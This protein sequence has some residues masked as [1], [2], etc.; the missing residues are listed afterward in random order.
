MRVMCVFPFTRVGRDIRTT[1]L[2]VQ[3]FLGWRAAVTRTASYRFLTLNAF[4]S[5]LPWTLTV[6]SVA[7]VSNPWDTPE[8]VSHP[9]PVVQ[10]ERLPS[11]VSV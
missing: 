2:R 11:P 6:S 8:G 10:G 3:L 7:R 9:L 4:A 1:R 5:T